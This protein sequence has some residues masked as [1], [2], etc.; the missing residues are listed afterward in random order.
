MENKR[1]VNQMH[2]V[3]DLPEKEGMGTQGKES[4]RVMMFYD[5]ETNVTRFEILDKELSKDAKEHIAWWL[6][7]NNPICEALNDPA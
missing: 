4:T 5:R 1:Y 6:Q 7:H 3:F 2:W